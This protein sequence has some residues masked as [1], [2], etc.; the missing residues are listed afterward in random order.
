MVN[1]LTVAKAEMAKK[2]EAEKAKQLAEQ[3]TAEQEKRQV[4]KKEFMKRLDS[5]ADEST[6]AE[7]MTT[8]TEDVFDGGDEWKSLMGDDAARGS[9]DA[10][11]IDSGDVPLASLVDQGGDEAEANEAKTLIEEM[12]PQGELTKDNL[13]MLDDKLSKIAGESKKKVDAKRSA[14]LPDD[15]E[16]EEAVKDP[17]EKRKWALLKKTVDRGALEPNSYLMTKFRESLKKEGDEEH[18]KGLSRLDAAKFRL[19]WSEKEQGAMR[20]EVSKTHMKSWQKVD[21]TR[22]KYKMLGQ[23]IVNDGGFNDKDAVEGW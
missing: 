15:D 22:G 7:T 16:V 9:A 5:I 12:A 11:A 19:Q 18:Y 14:D 4:A 10:M 3:T 21:T 2:K 8:V 1:I 13:K 17:K 23:I 20:K 6:R